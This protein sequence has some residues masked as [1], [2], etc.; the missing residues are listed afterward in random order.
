MK[1]LK[2]QKVYFKGINQEGGEVFSWLGE[3]THYNE[4]GNVTL[5]KKFDDSGQIFEV[6]ESFYEGDLLVKEVYDCQDEGTSMTTYYEYDEKGR[7]IKQQIDYE[8]Y[9]EFREFSHEGNST[10]VL[11]KDEDGVVERKELITLNSAEKPTKVEIFGEDGELEEK[12]ERTYTEKGDLH[13][14]SVEDKVQGYS[15]NQ[16]FEYDEKG[17]EKTLFN[18][19]PSGS[20]EVI[21]TRDIDDKDRPV[22][23]E[24]PGVREVVFEYDGD[25]FSTQTIYEFQ[26]GRQVAAHTEFHTKDDFPIKT[27]ST[28]NVR[29]FIV[30]SMAIM[31]SGVVSYEYHFEN[32]FYA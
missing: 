5:H 20:K 6:G 8:G 24:Y 15:S 1:K 10:T 11:V 26:H 2:S 13:T 17:N 16:E 7:A 3:E 30:D 29:S 9:S 21:Y 12:E 18:I 27:V 4:D 23:I 22:K 25:D 14:I 19:T 32:E 31:S 28:H